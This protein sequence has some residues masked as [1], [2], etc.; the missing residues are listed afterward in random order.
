MSSPVAFRTDTRVTIHRVRA[1]SAVFALV[2]LAVIK[3]NVTV[4]ANVPWGAVTPI[5]A[6]R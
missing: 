1:V 4:L 5:S 6:R 3:V 2:I